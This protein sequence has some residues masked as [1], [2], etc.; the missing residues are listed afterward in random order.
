M[1][2]AFLS[3]LIFVL[4]MAFVGGG[5]KIFSKDKKHDAVS[6]WKVAGYFF[7][8]VLTSINLAQ[9]I[10]AGTLTALDIAVMIVSVIEFVGNK[11]EYDKYYKKNK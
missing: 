5:I 8:I 1:K 10:F 3:V 2:V 6:T 4:I 11:I 9:S 7:V